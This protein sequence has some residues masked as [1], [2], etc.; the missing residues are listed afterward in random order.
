MTKID[1]EKKNPN[2]FWDFLD[3]KKSNKILGKINE[4]SKISKFQNFRNFKIFD[5]SLTFRKIFLENFFGRKFFE[6]I[7][8]PNFQNQISP[9]KI[10]IFLPDFFSSKDFVMYYAKM[11]STTLR[12]NAR[13][14]WQRS[15]E[16][17]P[18]ILEDFGVSMVLSCKASHHS[19]AL[20]LIFV[21]GS[22]CDCLNHW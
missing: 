19:R 8:N 18:W 2:I 6:N 7:S 15:R 1:F 4:K 14:F 17:N 16:K 10:N 9:R 22:Q 13:Q 3:Q 21:S 20:L 11:T 12:S 5:F